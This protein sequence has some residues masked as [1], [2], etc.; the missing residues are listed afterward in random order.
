MEA[1]TWRLRLD[2]GD[3]RHRSIF[4]IGDYRHSYSS[5]IGWSVFCMIVII[6]LTTD[7]RFT[8]K[9]C[10]WVNFQRWY[11][12]KLCPNILMQSQV[13]SKAPSLIYIY[14]WY[15]AYQMIFILWP[16]CSLSISLC[17]RAYAC[18]VVYIYSVAFYWSVI[19]LSWRY[20]GWFM[21]LTTD[22]CEPIT[23][24][25]MAWLGQRERERERWMNEWTNINNHH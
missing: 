22:L 5:H 17:V 15:L 24:E 20:S 18:E 9:L 21:W 16:V 11:E 12:R 13:S 14:I 7:K 6:L 23:W 3:V 10:F 8:A 25:L 2:F 1:L 19:T 4:V